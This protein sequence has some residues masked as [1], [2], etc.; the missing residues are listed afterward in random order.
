[1]LPPEEVKWGCAGN[2]YLQFKK[3]KPV[4]FYITRFGKT[5]E[6]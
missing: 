2:F 4:V 1:M 5:K 6:D 3:D